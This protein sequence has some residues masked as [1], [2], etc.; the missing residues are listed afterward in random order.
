MGRI[1]AEP[2]AAEDTVPNDLCGLGVVKGCVGRYG[3]KW[4]LLY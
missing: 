2:H 3:A 4:A 1:E